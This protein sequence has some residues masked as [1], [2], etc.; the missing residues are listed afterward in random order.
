VDA[1]SLTLPMPSMEGGPVIAL[2]CA[3]SMSI[4][5]LSP[6]SVASMAFTS[7]RR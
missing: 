7:T 4:G 6:A 5:A 3:A 2:A 1:S